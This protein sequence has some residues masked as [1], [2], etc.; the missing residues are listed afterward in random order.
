MGFE[1]RRRRR[2]GNLDL[3]DCSSE[4]MN[5]NPSPRSRSDSGRSRTIRV[6][7]EG[8]NQATSR[9]KEESTKGLA[10]VLGLILGLKVR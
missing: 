1:G 3:V 2:R 10:M 6:F 5:P 8:S 7:P 4:V 9:R